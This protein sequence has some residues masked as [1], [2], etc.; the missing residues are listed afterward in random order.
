[1]YNWFLCKLFVWIKVSNCVLCKFMIKFKHKYNNSIFKYIMENVLEKT[2][3][4][5]KLRNYS[6]KTI[7]AYTMYISQ[8]LDFSQKQKVTDRNKAIEKFLLAKLDRGN[9]SQTVNV[10][11][12]AIKFL[13]R[14]VLK[15]KDRIDFKCAKKSKKL[16]MVLLHSE[17]QNII[18]QLQNPKHKLIISLAYGSGLRISEVANLKVQDIDFDGL[19]IHIKSGKGKKDR[20][21]IFPKR[22]VSSMQEL[23]IHKQSDDFVFESNCGGRLTTTSL[24]KVFQNALKKS[25]IKKPATFHSLRHSFATHLLENGTDVRYVQELLGHANIR[26]TQIYTQVTNPQLKN[27]KSPL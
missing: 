27:I 14:E 15:S 4:I 11:L 2:K 18:S 5:L 13:Y 20:I 10:A 3:N 26:T 25:K 8:Y 12:N 9:S 16:P 22:L 19:S 17:I 1:M 21:T 6:P 23:I 7:K 24:Q